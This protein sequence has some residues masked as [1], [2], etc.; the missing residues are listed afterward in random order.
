MAKHR[1]PGPPNQ[2]SQAA[3]R[4]DADA[5]LAAYDK[6]RR[7]PMDIPRRHRPAHGGASHL[8]PD[9]ARV[10]EEWNWF[11]YEPVGT[12][13]NLAAAQAWM[14]QLQTDNGPAA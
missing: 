14:N 11:A 2:P 4:I 1:R 6:R 3:P 5:P 9:E 7:P 13:P 12:A 8:R 10:L